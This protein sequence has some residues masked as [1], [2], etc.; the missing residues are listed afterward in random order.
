MEE[1][2]EGEEEEEEEEEDTSKI[3]TH[4]ADDDTPRGLTLVGRRRHLSDARHAAP[5]RT[6][7]QGLQHSFNLSCFVPKRPPE[8]T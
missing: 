7:G 2:E 3:M 1:E 8:V 6:A 4:A 5:A